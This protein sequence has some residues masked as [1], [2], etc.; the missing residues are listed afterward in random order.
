MRRDLSVPE[1]NEPI[2]VKSGF[3]IHDAQI[4]EI[5]YLQFDVECDL[6]YYSFSD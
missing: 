2:Q 6:R 5:V 1:N 3:I 4:L